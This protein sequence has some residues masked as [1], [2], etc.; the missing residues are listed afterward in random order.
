MNCNLLVPYDATTSMPYCHRVTRV[1]EQKGFSPKGLVLS[2]LYLASSLINLI[3]R[4]VYFSY[5]NWDELLAIIL[6]D[7][8]QFTHRHRHLRR[9]V[10]HRKD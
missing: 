5:H 1:H 3:V 7:K 6:S 10:G 9:F 2:M 4:T 8:L